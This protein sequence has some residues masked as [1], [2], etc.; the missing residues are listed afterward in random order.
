[1][2]VRRRSAELCGRAGGRSCTR[3][4]RYVGCKRTAT[5]L[6]H[7]G[8]NRRLGCLRSH[9]SSSCSPQQQYGQ[10][11]IHSV[12]ARTAAGEQV[13]GQ[14]HPIDAEGV[15]SFRANGFLIKQLV[16]EEELRQVDDSRDL[17]DEVSPAHW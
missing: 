5:Q 10:A 1:M 14:S 4:C 11:H 7:S 9:L 2:C 6:Q 13:D 15:A 17:I 12:V 3:H 8:M 16:P